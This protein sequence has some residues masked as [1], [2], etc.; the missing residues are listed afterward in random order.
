MPQLRAYGGV[1]GARAVVRRKLAGS[2]LFDLLTMLGDTCSLL[3][4][5][6]LYS[7]HV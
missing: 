7:A 1:L 5:I 2:K 6:G 3:G 4:A